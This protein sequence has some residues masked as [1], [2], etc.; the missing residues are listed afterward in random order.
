M[1]QQE[2]MQNESSRHELFY[3]W[4]VVRIAS[5]FYRRIT[6]MTTASLELCKEL[7]GLSGR[8]KDG[9][10]NFYWLE[11]D[12]KATITRNRGQT[13]AYDLGYL[14]RKLPISTDGGKWKLAIYK[15]HHNGKNSD[16]YTFA[17]VHINDMGLIMPTSNIR[18]L[19]LVEAD[20]PED[21]ACKLAI[22]LFKQGVL[23]R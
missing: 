4:D 12:G 5:V 15:A 22:E 11:E 1:I 2:R 18:S 14:L 9:K 8:G 10:F 3:S 21:A 20:T 16:W 13:P 17:Y 6:E 19:H 7:Y 23:Q